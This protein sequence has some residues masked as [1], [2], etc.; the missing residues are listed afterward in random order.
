LHRA[1]DG[2][3]N[4]QHRGRRERRVYQ[5]PEACGQEHLGTEERARHGQAEH[6]HERLP[7]RSG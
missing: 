3:A 4:G 7:A 1:R 6:Q 5:P 2:Q